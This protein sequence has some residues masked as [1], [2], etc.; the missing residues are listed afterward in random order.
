MV[1]LKRLRPILTEITF[2]SQEKFSKHCMIT[3]SLI[4]SFIRQVKKLYYVLVFYSKTFI[5]NWTRSPKTSLPDLL[6][7]RAKQE[8]MQP[9]FS[10]LQWHTLL[11]NP[12]SWKNTLQHR[13]CQIANLT[14]VYSSVILVCSRI[15]AVSMR[16]RLC[17]VK[18]IMPC[19]EYSLK[20][21]LPTNWLQKSIN[22]SI[23]VASHL[24]SLNL[25]LS[26]TTSC[27]R[28]T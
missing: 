7:K 14:F 9:L 11:I 19:R 24:L 27:I 25:L 1:C 2:L 3:I 10:G 26:R 13:L 12:S 16:L 6:K 22:C 21:L 20:T 28:L 8:I 5:E 23:G 4:W 18:E 15:K 17:R